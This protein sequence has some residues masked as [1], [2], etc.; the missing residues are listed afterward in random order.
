MVGR[1]FRTP[2]RANAANHALAAAMKA[3]GRDH[4]SVAASA[5]VARSGLSR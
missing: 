1:L 5:A 3:G 2:S 4:C